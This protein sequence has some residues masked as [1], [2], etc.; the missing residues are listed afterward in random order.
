M[1]RLLLLAS[2]LAFPATAQASVACSPWRSQT[3]PPR[4]IR[5]LIG[6]R[7][8]RVPF[9]LY[10]ARVVASEWGSAPYELR[11]AGAVA[12]KEYAWSKAMNPRHS[13]F[14]CFDLHDDTRDQLYRPKS[15]PARVWQAVQATWSWRVLREGRLIQ[16]GYRS[17]AKV[18]CARDTDGFHLYARSARRCALAG[19]SAERILSVYFDARVVR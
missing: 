3:T 12:V 9:A 1:T 17:G 7:V 2:L 18:G 6:H 15:P 13:R 8:T 10:T 16:T 11:L 19:W 5:V 14:G 4:S